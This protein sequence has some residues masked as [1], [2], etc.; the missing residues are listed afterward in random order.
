MRKLY[1]EAALADAV[2]A[3]KQLYYLDQAVSL[4][5]AQAFLARDPGG[6]SCEGTSPIADIS[7]FARESALFDAHAQLCAERITALAAEANPGQAVA[8]F[9]EVRDFITLTV[10]RFKARLLTA[11]ELAALWAAG[12]ITEEQVAH[13][14]LVKSQGVPL[15]GLL[16]D[17]AD[18]FR[19]VPFVLR[20][21]DRFVAA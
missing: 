9:V 18:N 17:G 1:G 16:I 10:V 13:F 20:R 8:L 4:E 15:W 12:D 19:T 11:E 3:Q 2:A 14:D 21:P 5:E 7:P 6:V